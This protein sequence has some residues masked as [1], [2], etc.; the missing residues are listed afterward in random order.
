MPQGL[1]DVGT[2]IP[3]T[4]GG[5]APPPAGPF[6]TTSPPTSSQYTLPPPTAMPQR[7]CFAEAIATTGHIEAAHAPPWQSWPQAPQFLASLVV[8]TQALPQI[9]MP[10]PVHDSPP[11]VPPLPGPVVELV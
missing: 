1:P 4:R 3:E 6:S 5:D 7:S 11:S 8:S 10:A 9:I 2:L